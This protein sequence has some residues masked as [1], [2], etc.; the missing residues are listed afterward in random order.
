MN[1][2]P[3]P[4]W[5]PKAVSRLAGTEISALALVCAVS[6]GETAHVTAYVTPGLAGNP[7]FRHAIELESSYCEALLRFDDCDPPHYGRG[8]AAEDIDFASVADLIGVDRVLCLAIQTNSGQIRVQRDYDG[9]EV[10]LLE[11]ANTQLRRFMKMLDEQYAPLSAP[12]AYGTAY[13]LQ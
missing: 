2:F 9:L 1:V 3:E 4:A 13:A 8:A 11:A 10:T 5:V 7:A 12:S 6:R